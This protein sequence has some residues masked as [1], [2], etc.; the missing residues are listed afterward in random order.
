MPLGRPGVRFPHIP[1]R[2]I[3]LDRQVVRLQLMRPT[4]EGQ[5]PT[6]CVIRTLFDIDIKDL[7]ILIWLISLVRLHILDDM[8]RF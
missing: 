7:D 3:D 8:P 2:K 4:S 5:C 6:G 1:L